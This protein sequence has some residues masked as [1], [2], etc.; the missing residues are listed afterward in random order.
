VKFS[1]SIR[2]YL[3]TETPLQIPSKT[4]TAH[5]HSIPHPKPPNQE[6]SPGISQTDAHRKS[7]SPAV[8]QNSFS[9]DPCT[10][11]ALG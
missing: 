1:N 2:G 10:P 8:S 9:T 6:P 11:S 7:C 3:P 5:F 4:T